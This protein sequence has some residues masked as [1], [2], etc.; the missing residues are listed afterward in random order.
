VSW[1]NP[2]ARELLRKTSTFR[3]LP[4]PVRAALIRSGLQSKLRE[5][6]IELSFVMGAMRN[7]LPPDARV[8]A[9]FNVF[10]E[11]FWR[12]WRDGGDK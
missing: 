3:A 10:L 2:D 7:V 1:L 4:A 6:D 8:E 11:E 9:A 12:W 5:H